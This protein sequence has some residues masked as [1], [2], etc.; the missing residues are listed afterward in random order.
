MPDAVDFK[1]G[2]SNEFSSLIGYIFIFNLIIGTGTLALPKAF[3]DA[4]YLLATIIIIVLAVFSYMAFTFVV[5]SM[6]YANALNSLKDDQKGEMA[7]IFWGKKG[8]YTFYAFL[9]VY[10]YGDLAIYSTVVPKSLM[11]IV[12]TDYLGN[13]TNSSILNGD[14]CWRKTYK[15]SRFYIYRLFVILFAVSIGS[16]V[17]FNVSKTK[18]LQIFT[19][20]YRWAAFLLMICLALKIILAGQATGHPG[21][22]NMR[23]FANLFGI[24]VYA[25]M[26]HHSLPSVIT[27]MNSKKFIYSRTALIYAL[28]LFFYVTISSTG[29][30]A[31]AEVCDVYTLNFLSLNRASTGLA[32]VVHTIIDYFLALFPVFS[33][34]TNFPIVG[35]TLRNNLIS[36]FYEMK[37][38]SNGDTIDISVDNGKKIVQKVLIPSLVVLPPVFISC[39][40]D[41]VEILASVTGSYAGVGVQYVLPAMLIFGA[42]KKCRNLMSFLPNSHKSPFA[43]KFWIFGLFAWAA[44]SVVLVT[45]N[46]LLDGF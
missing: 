42:R 10:L 44:L 37:E 30:F 9:V 8:L 40:T 26:C 27:P 4:G 34:T 11:T 45:M 36:L 25:F 20:I 5:E 18:Y 39:L 7:L 1:E 17:F 22:F 32:F 14:P 29:S 2:R 31:F 35:V 16:F 6:S 15:V 43:S 41:N 33:L 3:Q 23:K 13:G 24:S 19:S 12:C 21:A 46:H 28:I 38:H